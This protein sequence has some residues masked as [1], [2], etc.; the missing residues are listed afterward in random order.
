MERD[1]VPK[2]PS[3]LGDLCTLLQNP[4]LP[5]LLDQ[6]NRLDANKALKDPVALKPDPKLSL[7]QRM[8]VSASSKNLKRSWT[9]SEEERLPKRRRSPQSSASSGRTL[10]SCLLNCKEKHS[11]TPISRKSSQSSLLGTSLK[12][13]IRPG[14]DLV[15]LNNPLTR[16]SHRHLSGRPESLQDPSQTTMTISVAAT[17]LKVNLKAEVSHV[18]VQVTLHFLM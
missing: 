2:P 11:S 4:E 5:G 10:M 15:N 7:L 8:D 17:R 3:L 1:Q 9:P 6:L 14:L 18:L 13:Q 12:D 16:P